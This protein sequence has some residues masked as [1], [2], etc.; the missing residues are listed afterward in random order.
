MLLNVNIFARSRKRNYICRPKHF[1]MNP[2]QQL[3]EQLRLMTSGQLY[4][5][6]DNAV[7]LNVLGQTHERCYD[8]NLLRP[9]QTRQRDELIRL[10]LG[11]AGAKL[12]I[13]SPFLC[14]YGF[15][16]SVGENF[17][18]NAGLIILDEAPV[19]FGDNVFIGPNC[20]FYTA[21]HPLEADL[22]DAGLEYARPIAVG[23]SVW[24]GGN[25]AVMPGATIG[26]RAVIGGGSV[27]VGDIPPDTLAVGNPCRVIRKINQ[28]ADS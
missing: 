3:Q 4:P 16:I 21:G 26:D 9:S 11:H 28:S 2:D 5:A 18:A 24:I 22:R 17:F 23:N 12:K 1:L 13:I 27:V 14:D 6:T 25:T 19:T 8:Y 15:N 20:G 7:L 10:I